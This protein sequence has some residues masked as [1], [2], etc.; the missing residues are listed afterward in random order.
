MYGFFKLNPVD[1]WDT[2]EK[3][4][5]CYTCLKPRS[6]CYARKCTYYEKVPEALK[7]ALCALWA[8]SKG[9]A[10]FSIFFCRHKTHRD[11][12]APLNILRTAL[13]GYIGKLRA[14]IVDSTIGFSVNFMQVNSTTME[15]DVIIETGHGATV[16]PQAPIIDSETGY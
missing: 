14:D 9:S 8:E 4:R 5:M 13:E 10:P 2:L 3:G 15:S 1:R 16:F 12:R 7:C 11:A 6:A